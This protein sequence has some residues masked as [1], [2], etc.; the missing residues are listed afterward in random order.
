M[1]ADRV[2]ETTSRAKKTTKALFEFQGE[3]IF[4]PY[5]VVRT[6]G[7]KIKCEQSGVK[8]CRLEAVRQPGEKNHRVW[9]WVRKPDEDTWKRDSMYEQPTLARQ[10]PDDAL[11]S[12][13][14]Y[15]N[16]YMTRY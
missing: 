13:I 7:F 14:S 15:I 6:I 9:V 3:A 8:E 10:N 11:I 5:E 12:A 16:Q 2:N 4:E 1:E